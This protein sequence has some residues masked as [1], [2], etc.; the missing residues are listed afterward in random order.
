MLPMN[1]PKPAT[2][3]EI[4][5]LCALNGV[6]VRKA[7]GGYHVV[8]GTHASGMMYLSMSISP[9]R[10]LEWWIDHMQFIMQSLKV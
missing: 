1:K 9:R 4:K 7:G 6:R 5:N 3:R 2:M 8:R 10:S